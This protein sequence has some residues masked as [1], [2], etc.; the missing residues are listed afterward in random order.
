MDPEKKEPCSE[1]LCCNCIHKA[2]AD[3]AYENGRTFQRK[4]DIR[5]LK[6]MPSYW[7]DRI[8]RTFKNLEL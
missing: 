8:V 7:I 6:T 4:E 1:I 2:I 5:I 3:R